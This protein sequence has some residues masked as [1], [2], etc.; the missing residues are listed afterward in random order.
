MD[1]QNRSC[2]SSSSGTVATAA[3]EARKLQFNLNLGTL[4]GVTKM[5]TKLQ[6][7]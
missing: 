3:P 4:A 6:K 2:S 1:G 5:Q 7:H